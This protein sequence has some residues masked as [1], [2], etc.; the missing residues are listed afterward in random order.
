MVTN[1]RIL[2][3][4]FAPYLSGRILKRSHMRTLYSALLFIMMEIPL[5]MV[6]RPLQLSFKSFKGKMGHFENAKLDKIKSDLI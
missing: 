1:L 4:P 6:F 2:N 3:I 5:I